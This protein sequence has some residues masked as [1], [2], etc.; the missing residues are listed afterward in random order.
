MNLTRRR[1]RR[2]DEEEGERVAAKHTLSTAD[3]GQGEIK[4]NQREWIWV[5]D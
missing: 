4:T 3:R 5:M 1:R 2:A